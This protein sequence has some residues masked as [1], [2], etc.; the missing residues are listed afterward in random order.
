MNITMEQY[1]L[2]HVIYI[3]AC[4]HLRLDTRVN[5]HIREGAPYFKIHKKKQIIN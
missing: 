3:S 4:D 5:K 2:E 1:N